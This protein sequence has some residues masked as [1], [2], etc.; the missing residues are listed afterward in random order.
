MVSPMQITRASARARVQNALVMTLTLWGCKICKPAKSGHSIKGATRSDGNRTT[1]WQI[2]LSKNKLEKHYFTVKMWF[3]ILVLW[4]IEHIYGVYFG[5]QPIGEFMERVK[6]HLTQQSLRKIHPTSM[7]RDE[8][9]GIDFCE[10]KCCCCI[11]RATLPVC[12]MSLRKWRKTR[13]QPSRK[14]N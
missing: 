13:Q 3:W 8:V 10:D 2:L 5:L 9:D 1:E 12:G 4:N 7:H 11:I 14:W 6:F